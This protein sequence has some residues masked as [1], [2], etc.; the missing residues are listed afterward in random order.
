MTSTADQAWVDHPAVA[1][2]WANDSSSADFPMPRA[3]DEQYAASTFAG[4]KPVEDRPL[5]H[6]PDEGAPP[7]RLI[8][9]VSLPADSGRTRDH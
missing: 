3:M 8:H 7:D 6:P 1:A 4:Q 2:C 5:A 9:A